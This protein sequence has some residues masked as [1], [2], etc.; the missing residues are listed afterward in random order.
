[1]KDALQTDPL[2]ALRLKVDRPGHGYTP[3]QAKKRMELLRR[4]FVK[5]HTEEQARL[6]IHE[7][8]RRAQAQEALRSERAL[9]R[10]FAP[11]R[12]ALPPH[13]RVR[14]SEIE[15]LLV[16]DQRARGP[17]ADARATPQADV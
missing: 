13:L 14:L 8:I 2:R 9:I 16:N 10:G 1:M 4:N 17:R 6:D 11:R 7:R 5:R 12:D 15:G 3:F